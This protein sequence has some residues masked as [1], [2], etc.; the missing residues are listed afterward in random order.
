[1]VVNKLQ[2]KRVV[3]DAPIPSDSNIKTKEHKR[4]QKY[5]GLKEEVEK[6]W[7]LKAAVVPLVIRA[8]GAVPPILGEWFQQIPGTTS[9]SFVQ[10]SAIVVRSKILHKT[11]ML[12]GPW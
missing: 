5:H 3:I 4:L 6:M 8:L 9:E 1:M 10:K 12:P 7:E 11:L 2:K